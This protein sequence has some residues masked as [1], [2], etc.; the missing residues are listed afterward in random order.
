M[1]VALEQKKN[2][3][4]FE[5][6]AGFLSSDLKDNMYELIESCKKLKMIPRWYATNSF[7][8]KYKGKMV[9]RFRFFENGVVDLYFTVTNMND[10]DSV[11][12]NLSEDMRKFY[13]ANIRRCLH[14]NPTHGD[15]KKV[16]ILNN[17]YWICAAPEMFVKNPSKEQI[18]YLTK[19]IA[20][21]REYINSMV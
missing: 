16:H 10:I 2:K 18:G 1:S 9:F 17:D 8:V 7:N 11:L 4:T 19:F 14:C 13:F 20:I 5:Q 15:G 3:P 6:L 21:R 12:S